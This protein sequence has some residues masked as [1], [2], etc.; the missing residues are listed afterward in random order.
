MHRSLQWWSVPISIIRNKISID[1]KLWQ[2]QKTK[3]E[4]MNEQTYVT[5]KLAYRSRLP[6]HCSALIVFVRVIF[7][8]H[9]IRGCTYTVLPFFFVST[10]WSPFL[11]LLFWSQCRKQC[12]Y[13][14]HFNVAYFNFFF[15]IDLFQIFFSFFVSCL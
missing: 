9:R 1:V 2:K 7:Y 13:I 11:S 8:S 6:S 3:Y 5:R 12:L 10:K 14:Y 4:R 15:I